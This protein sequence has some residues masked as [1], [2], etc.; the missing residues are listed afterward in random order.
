MIDGYTPQ[1]IVKQMGMSIH[2]LRSYEHIGLLDSANRLQ[3]GHRRY[4]ETD[5]KRLV[6]LKRL[7][8]TGMPISDMVTYVR[9]FHQGDDTIAE[10]QR[11]LEEHR[12]KVLSQIDEHYQ[13]VA[14]LDTK[15]ENYR[16][17]QAGVKTGIP[18]H[19]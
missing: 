15:I 11:M 6:F 9:L 5:L 17:Q 3:N 8:A 13:T 4:S 1:E 7:K 10:R 16:R 14:L 19:V 12:L 2:T 18:Q